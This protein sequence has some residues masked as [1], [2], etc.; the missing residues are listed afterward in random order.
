MTEIWA[1]V[2]K[3]VKIL[4][5]FIL[6]LWWCSFSFVWKPRGT[7]EDR[8]FF[9]LLNLFSL[10][11]SWELVETYLW[12]HVNKKYFRGNFFFCHQ[13]SLKMFLFH[14]VSHKKTKMFLFFFFMCKTEL[15]RN[16]TLCLRKEKIKTWK[17]KNTFCS[18]LDIFFSF[19]CEKSSWK[20]NSPI[21][22][23]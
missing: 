19:M 7:N 16:N 12:K 22:F 14:S 2:N 23:R 3:Y 1:G 4:F 6:I 8:L 17:E 15:R 13:V 18:L 20:E 11:C 9:H 5:T 10:L 21:N